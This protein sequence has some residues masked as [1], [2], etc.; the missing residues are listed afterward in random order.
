MKR[1]LAIGQARRNLVARLCSECKDVRHKAIAAHG[2]V[3]DVQRF[4]FDSTLALL[5]A[6]NRHDAEDLKQEKRAHLTKLQ[7]AMQIAAQT[8]RPGV[9]PS[10]CDETGVR[11]N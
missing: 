11:L 1:K 6:A 9:L 3:F 2:S 8:Q 4:S 10:I 5:R 7:H